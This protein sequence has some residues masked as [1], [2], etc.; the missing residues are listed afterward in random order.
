MP[1]IGFGVERAELSPQQR[2]V[3][4]ESA[5]VDPR[6]EAKRA[7]REK[8]HVASLVA[9]RAWYEE[10]SEI[11]RAAIKRRDYLIRVGLAKR[12]S[13]KKAGKPGGDE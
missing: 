10:W 2:T 9:L 6:D 1:A 7:E 12:K 3:P 13:A 8:K 4:S 11:A 5:P